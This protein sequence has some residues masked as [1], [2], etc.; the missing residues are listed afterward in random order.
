MNMASELRNPSATK[1]AL[2]P[3]AVPYFMVSN[4]NNNNNNNP[5]FT[6]QLSRGISYHSM[7]QYYHQRF[8]NNN[9]RHEKLSCNDNQEA[10]RYFRV[11][12]STT[13]NKRN[14]KWVP[15]KDQDSPA[16]EKTPVSP[17]ET[18]GGQDCGTI[19]PFP[20]DVDELEKLGKT[21]VMVKNIPNQYR[22]S[23]SLPYYPNIYFGLLKKIRVFFV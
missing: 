21:T 14:F 5:Y 3:N 6:A 1:K 2:D 13:P 18:A 9:I 19:I 7:A 4:N 15:K 8:N 12:N 22:S 20:S 17:S 10:R 11:L 16:P 23:L